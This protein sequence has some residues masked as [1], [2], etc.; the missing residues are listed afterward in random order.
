MGGFCCK[1]LANHGV[2]LQNR[3]LKEVH[4]TPVLQLSLQKSY[5]TESQYLLKI[6]WLLIY[7][8]QKRC[9]IYFETVFTQ[10]WLLNFK[11]N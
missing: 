9:Q 4:V 3:P 6:D 2:K 8:G 5:D 7:A 1:N 10:K 11:D